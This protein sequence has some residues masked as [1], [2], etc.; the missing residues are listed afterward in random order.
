M[1]VAQMTSNR[2]RKLMQQFVQICIRTLGKRVE[3]KIQPTVCR[4]KRHTLNHPYWTNTEVLGWVTSLVSFVQ[5]QNTLVYCYCCGWHARTGW[6]DSVEVTMCFGYGSWRNQA[7]TKLEASVLLTF[8]ESESAVLAA[9]GEYYYQL[10]CL[11]MD[12][13]IKGR[14]CSVEE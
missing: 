5:G 3:L 4:W 13:T 8:T 2:V 14:V 1:G 12:L 6:Q 10:S 11:V 9:S 7:R